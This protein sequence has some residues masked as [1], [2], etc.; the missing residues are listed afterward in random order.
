MSRAFKT[1][2]DSKCV[3]DDSLVVRSNMDHAAQDHHL[4]GFNHHRYG[5]VQHVRQGAVRRLSP[6]PWPHI[7]LEHPERE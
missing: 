3:V 2:C 4:P 6:N 7:K 1:E 5:D